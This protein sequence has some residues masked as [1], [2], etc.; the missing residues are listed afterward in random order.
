MVPGATQGA[1]H[2]QALNFAPLDVATNMYIIRVETCSKRERGVSLCGLRAEGIVVSICNGNVAAVYC[3]AVNWIHI[4]LNARLLHR[5]LHLDYH[6][7][8][9]HTLQPWPKI[10]SKFPSTPS[11]PA[12]SRGT[13]D[14]ILAPIFMPTGAHTQKP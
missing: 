2:M 8:H 9:K 14:H 7:Q 4:R 12:C 6:H 13:N 10:P 1:R 5:L 11:L 3:M